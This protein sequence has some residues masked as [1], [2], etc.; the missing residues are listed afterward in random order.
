MIFYLWCAQDQ[1]DDDQI[2]RNGNN[3]VLKGKQLCKIQCG[4]IEDS[5]LLSYP[6]KY[7]FSLNFKKSSVY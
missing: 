2:L 3:N 1:T 7:E 6:Q 4:I 5:K